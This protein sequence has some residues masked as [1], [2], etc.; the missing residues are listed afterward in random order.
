MPERKQLIFLMPSLAGGG[1]ERVA[2]T[3]LPFLMQEFDLTLAMLEDRRAYDIPDNL[4]VVSFS[5]PIKG[6]IKH[7][8]SIPYHINALV[9]LVREKKAPVVLSFLEQANIINCL[10][11]RYTRH[12]AVISQRTEPRRQYQGKGI[13]GRV[14]LWASKKT[15][16]MASHVISVSQGIRDIIAEDYKLDPK[17]IIVIPNPINIET[18]SRQSLDAPSIKLPAKFLLHV[19]RLRLEVKGQD[20]LLNAFAKISDL[21]PELQLVFVGEGPDRKEIEVLIAQLN[22][23]GR[24]L[25]TGWQENVA[26]IMARSQA[27]VLSS[28]YEG[29]PNALVEAMALGCPVIATDCIT[30][31]RE[32]LGDNEY[33][34]LVSMDNPDALASSIK[35]LLEDKEKR[36]HYSIQAKKRS[37]DFALDKVGRRY[38]DVLHRATS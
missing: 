10:A 25:F 16:P 31:P 37:I 35:C 33:G 8:T 9:H 24:V 7:I 38:V 36:E 28:S 11:S 3:L 5:P 34:L 32:I 4:P 2:A 26:A 21:F 13:L 22:L 1:A 6:A 30:G 27:F 18:L 15:Y 14:I 29:W 12:N 20:L 19:G 17:R 23:N